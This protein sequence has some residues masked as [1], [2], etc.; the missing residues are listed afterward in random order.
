MQKK[1]EQFW[2]KSLSGARLRQNKF[3]N[4][5]GTESELV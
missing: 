2:G 5:M 1:I 4:I 3:S